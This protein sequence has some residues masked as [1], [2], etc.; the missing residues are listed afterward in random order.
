MGVVIVVAVGVAFLV[1][2][3]GTL[4]VFPAMWW[5]FRDQR[6]R[7]SPERRRRGLLGAA[8]SAAAAERRAKPAA[9]PRTADRG[10]DQRRLNQILSVVP[11]V[12][13]NTIDVGVTD[14]DHPKRKRSLR[15]M[16]MR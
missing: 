1:T 12:V 13:T 7:F 14:P 15:A 3:V 2:F 10:D 16:A 5:G 4:L 11:N 9:D 8:A 6:R